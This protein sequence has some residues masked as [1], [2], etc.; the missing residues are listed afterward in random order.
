MEDL[1]DGED[2]DVR[3][4]NAEQHLA[5]DDGRNGDLQPAAMGQASAATE[6]GDAG[7]K[8]EPGKAAMDEVNPTRLQLMHPFGARVGGMGAGEF[9]SEFA[10]LGAED[11][12]GNN[13]GKQNP[14]EPAEL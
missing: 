1:G 6:E 2:A 3:E 11:T 8:D 10:H 5:D 9:I 4:Q 7:D 13:K 14:S 12:F